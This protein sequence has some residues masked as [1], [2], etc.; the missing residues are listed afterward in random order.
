MYWKKT[1][2]AAFLLSSLNIFAQSPPSYLPTEGLVGWWP[3]S[4]NALDSSTNGNN[5]IVS[6]AVLTTDR[7]GKPN[8]AYNFNGTDSRID[9]AD[10][11]SLRVRKIT[12][13]AWIK[14]NTQAIK[15]IIYN[16][17]RGKLPHC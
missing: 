14:P 2:L 15:Y 7:F 4:G 1:L 17:I 11:P 13:S 12:M 6:N 3:F 16:I 9:V 8:A 10:A 5:G